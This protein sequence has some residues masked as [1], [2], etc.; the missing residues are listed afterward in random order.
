MMKNNR[1]LLI[2]ITS[3]VILLSVFVLMLVYF[4]PWGFAVLTAIIIGAT[5]T[6][7]ISLLIFPRNPTIAWAALGIGYG[8]IVPFFFNAWGLIL[9]I[10]IM[11]ALLFLLIALDGKPS[12]EDSFVTAS[13]ALLGIVFIVL[14]LGLAISLR[15]LPDG[16]RILGLLFITTW[17]R[18]IGAFALGQWL[19]GNSAHLL[20]PAISPRKTF[21]GAI[22]GGV[23]ALLAAIAG[24]I[25][26]VQDMSL[27]FCILFALLIG[28]VGQI[29][30]LVESQIKRVG[31]AIDSSTLIPGQG[32][33][34]D[35]LDG[36]LYA[37][38]IFYLLLYLKL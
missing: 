17:G 28:I 10:L 36:F 35:A 27:L 6:E 29:G 31:R 13:L 1:K 32:G 25:W 4:P 23:V 3:V 5:F 18:D 9:G 30:D 38:P 20:N 7:Y 33:L 21:E 22:R 2:R 11:S 37:T 14:P 8:C 34:L 24:K 15:F 16:N 19:G 12:L 26:F